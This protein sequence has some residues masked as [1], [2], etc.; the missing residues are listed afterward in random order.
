MMKMVMVFVNFDEIPGCQDVSACN[1]N[2]LATDPPIDVIDTGI[3]PMECSYLDEDDDGVCDIFEISGC[4]D[5]LACNYDA[6]PTTDSD[7]SLCLYAMAC[8]SCSG[9]QDGTGYIINNDE[10][11]M[12]FVIMMKFKVVKI[13]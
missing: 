1:Y 8:E 12:E 13:L 4:T 5:Y 2:P 7:N 6:T 9:E 3:N 11:M 10:I